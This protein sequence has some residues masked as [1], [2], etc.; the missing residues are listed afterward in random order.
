MDLKPIT[1]E[2]KALFDDF[3]RGKFNEC[4]YNFT[5]Q[6][7]WSVGENSGYTL[8]QG[9]DVLTVHCIFNGVHYTY[10]P[11]S[12]TDNMDNVKAE[13]REILST[14]KALVTHVPERYVPAL[15]SEFVCVES[16][17]SFDYVYN[18]EDL[19]TLK[20]RK[21]SKKKNRINHFL[22][23]YPDYKY[24]QINESNIPDVIKFQEKWYEY[25]K[26]EQSVPILDDENQG[27]QTLLNNFGKLDYKG[28][29]LRV[30]DE[31]ACYTLGEAINDEWIVVH[32]E[33]GFNEYVGCYQM[34][35]REFLAREFSGYKY[36]NREDD[37]GEEG[38]REAKNSYHPAMMLVKYDITGMK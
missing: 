22:A 35:N 3:M 26:G 4:D 15:E 21:Y 17:D 12:K 5:N 10:M 2:D 8:T 23:A 37:F 13:L 27:I 16:R 11:I 31:I 24:E 33:K 1:I 18:F 7:L 38:L 29:L 28:C 20:G 30:G 9:G 19:S 36:V 34:I 32:I 14:T 6:F 25:H